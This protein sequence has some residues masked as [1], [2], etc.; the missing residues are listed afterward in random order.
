MKMILM[1]C[2]QPMLHV[3]K[4]K[5]C[6]GVIVK[7]VMKIHQKNKKRKTGDTMTKREET[8]QCVVDMA[9]EF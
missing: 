2:I 1:Q 5:S 8:E 4:R 9:E 7:I 6:Y 3:P